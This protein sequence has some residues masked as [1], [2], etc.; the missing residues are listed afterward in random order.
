MQGVHRFGSVPMMLGG[1]S[2]IEAGVALGEDASRSREAP[3]AQV[4]GATFMAKNDL[5]IEE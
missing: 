2:G 5:S 4:N 1:H 3:E